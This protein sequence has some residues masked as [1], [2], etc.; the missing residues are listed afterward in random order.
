VNPATFEQLTEAD[1][2]WIYQTGTDLHLAEETPV[3]TAGQPATSLM[4]VIEG[5][6]SVFVPSAAAAQIA[7]LGPGEVVG[8][9]SLLE[10]R[11][12][13]VSVKCKEATHLLAVPHSTLRDRFAQDPAFA[14][15]FFEGMA[16][17]LS[18]RLRQTSSRLAARDL[19]EEDLRAAGGAWKTVSEAVTQLK[20]RL[21]DI[22]AQRRQTRPKPGE[23]LDA[24]EP[25]KHAQEFFRLLERE[26]GDGSQEN[27]QIKEQIG[28]YVHKELLPFI[29]LTRFAERAYSKPRGYAGDYHTI[30]ILYENRPTGTGRIGPLIDQCFLA[31]PPAQ[32]VRNRRALLTD[33]IGRTVANSNGRTTQ[34]TSL[35]CGPATEV[36]D[37]FQQIPDPTA[38]SVNLLDIDLQAL[39][40]VA[41][42]R[43]EA[44]LQNRMRLLNDNLI[45]LALGRTKTDIHDQDLVYSIGL[46][47][48][49]NDKLVVKLMN[50][51]HSMLRP[52]GKVILGNFHPRNE[53]KAMM[54]HVLDWKLIHRT[55]EDMDRLYRQSHFGR[56]CTRVR[57]EDQQINLF[58]ECIKREQPQN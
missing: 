7:T 35:A 58:A 48:Y 5:V 41:E 6:L 55:E 39:A 21:V 30:A 2:E 31:C 38:L 25:V 17:T 1:M 13:T 26:I 23:P 27:P 53:C 14:R 20:Q 42:K 54:D 3:I 18:Q 22:D 19:T 52:G 28:A 11:P 51:V 46:I 37:A 15:R 16:K 10:D 49:F 8:D 33:E 45:Y 47:D 50:L 4:V 40:H 36:F 29:L 44:R 56:P 12:P 57:F 34:V 9:M 24:A 32:A 43:E